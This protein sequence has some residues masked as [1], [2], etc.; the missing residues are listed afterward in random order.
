MRNTLDF[1]SRIFG[2][3][4]YLWV[5][6]KKGCVIYIHK[7]PRFVYLHK[8]SLSLCIVSFFVPLFCLRSHFCQT[9]VFATLFYLIF[10]Y[11]FILTFQILCGTYFMCVTIF[12]LFV[13]HISLQVSR[14]PN[15][16]H[17]FVPFFIPYRYFLLICIHFTSSISFYLF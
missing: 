14:S 1:K 10:T 2:P 8:F 17:I 16:Q 12:L 15:K 5:P 9:A 3:K 13:F 4:I 7:Y 6:S 11:P